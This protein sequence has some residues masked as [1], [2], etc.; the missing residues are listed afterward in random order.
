MRSI[1]VWL[2]WAVIA[3]NFSS[4]TW[5]LLAQ[6]NQRLRT[7]AL[8]PFVYIGWAVTLVQ[9]TI[10]VAAIQ[11]GGTS[12]NG[13]NTAGGLHYFYGFLCMAAI[14]IIYSYRPQIEQWEYLLFGA[15]NLFIMGLAIRA[16]LLQ[17]LP[18]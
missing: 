13:G 11:G 5:A 9:V 10:G 15:G 2:A 7:A 14:A 17:P 6:W 4:G 8:I 3:A 12:L 16:M 18:V 1:H